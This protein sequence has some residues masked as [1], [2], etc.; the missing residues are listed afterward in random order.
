MKNNMSFKCGLKISN[1][2]YQTKIDKIMVEPK[3]QILVSDP[4]LPRRSYQHMD[5]HT[6][7]ID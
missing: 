6:I 4:K 7:F 3:D 5:Q 2:H 1:A